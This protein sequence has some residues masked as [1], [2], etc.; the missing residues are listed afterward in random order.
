MMSNGRI[1]EHGLHDELMEANNKYA[2]MVKSM[3]SEVEL[4]ANDG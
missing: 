3:M 2:S 1:V 4:E